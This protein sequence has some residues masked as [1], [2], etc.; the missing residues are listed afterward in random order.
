[1]VWDL[2][3]ALLRKEEF[4]SARLTDFE[5]RETVRALRLTIAELG[6]EAKPMLHELADH[7]VEAALAMLAAN[8]GRTEAEVESIYLRARVEARRQLIKE[9][10]DPSPVRLG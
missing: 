2:R 9:R 4:E 1:M 8:A 6:A 7:G 10:G 3:A 5:F